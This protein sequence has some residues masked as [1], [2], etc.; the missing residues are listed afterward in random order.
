M[1]AV[2]MLGI[3]K[4]Y[5]DGV[6]ALRGVDFEVEEGEIHGL[7][8]ENGAGKTTLMRILYGE[9]HA[10]DGE[11]KVFGRR[12]RFRSPRDAI[13]HGIA[14]IYQHFSLV[15][16]MSVLDNLYLSM[17]AVNPGV[18]RDDTE[19]RAE[20]LI[21][22]T[23]LRIPLGKTVEELPVGV[24][25]RVEIL[26]ALIRDARILILDEPTSVLTP[27]EVEELF[28][29]LRRLRDK[30]ITI[31]LITHKLREAK[32]ITDRVT[33]LRRGSKVGTVKTSEASEQQL[34]RMMVARDVELV[35]EKPPSRG[36]G[37]E[38]LR[39]EDIWVKG[40]EGVDALRGVSLVVREGE[41]LG[42]AGVQGNGQTELCETIAGLRKPYKGRILLDSRDVTW[43]DTKERYRLGIAYIP[44]SRKIGLIHD[45]SVL[46][47]SILTS[48]DEYTGRLGIVNWKKAKEKAVEVIKE[49]G[50]QPPNPDTPVKFL[51]GGNQQKLMVGREI[52][53]KPRILV[54]AEPTQGVDV[55]STEFIR[56]RLLELRN[57][58]IGILLVSTDLDEIFQLSD[59]VAVMYEGRIMGEGRVEEFTPEKIGLLMGGVNA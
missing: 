58:G 54:V 31:I 41:I 33:V 22:E 18:S 45:M 52:A 26:K 17:S 7:L 3:R 37:R 14:M 11:I 10:T 30:G 39:I 56:K 27:L 43:L 47:N 36:P 34:A 46:E 12:V 28:T 50:V 53:R 2:E 38:V 4:I 29:S 51:S 20:K 57:Q 19:E 24:Q 48:I 23:G 40:G 6:V 5:P 55:A 9:I 8:G 16:T 25:Q 13:R 59:R 49:Y 21:A 15:P 35:I 44:E 32:A 1:K 42:I